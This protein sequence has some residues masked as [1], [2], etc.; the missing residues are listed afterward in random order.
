MQ[1]F[2]NNSLTKDS[3]TLT[4]DKVESRHIINSLRKKDGDTLYITNGLAQLFIS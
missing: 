2:Y 3:Q 4:F 1:L